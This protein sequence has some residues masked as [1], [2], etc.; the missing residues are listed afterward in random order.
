[1]NRTLTVFLAFSVWACAEKT[2]EFERYQLEKVF[3]KAQKIVKRIYINPRLAP[4]S[5]YEDAKKLLLQV[6]SSFDSLEINQDNTLIRLSLLTLAQLELLQENPQEAIRFYNLYLAEAGNGKEN[7]L[8]VRINLGILYEKILAYQN[9]AREYEKVLDGLIDIIDP[10]KPQ[11][12]LMA[13]PFQYTRIVTFD[14]QEGRPQISD[15]RSTRVYHEILRRWP[16]S[17]A[18][19]VALNYLSLILLQNQ[20]YDQLQEILQQQLEVTKDSLIVPY[21]KFFQAKTMILQG[22]AVNSVIAK[23]QSIIQNFPQSEVVPPAKLELG[24]IYLGQRQYEKSRTFFKDIV[25]QHFKNYNIAAEAQEQIALSF[26]LEGRWDQAL[27]EYRWLSK[28]FETSMPGLTAPLKIANY[29][30]SRNNLSLAEQAFNEAIEFYQELIRKYPKSMLAA[31]AQEQ[32]SK[33]FLAQEKYDQAVDAVKKI[34]D[35]WTNSAGTISTYLLLGK[36]YEASNQ[37]TLAAKA[38]KEIA[39]QF[40]QHPLAP[41]FDEKARQ[42]LN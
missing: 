40:P 39:T 33:C 3:F 26:E 5:D 11:P 42:L 34:K 4:I 15:D 12:Y 19:L 6:V 36:I 21:I 7:E 8:S 10:N 31:M 27:N 17:K 14:H 41:F 16:N 38:Y 2:P 35:I 9:A 23:L 28:Q 30:L 1:M 32:I 29:Y 13:I 37:Y 18:A 25:T 24:K 20:N 22:R